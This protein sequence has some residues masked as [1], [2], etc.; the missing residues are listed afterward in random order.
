MTEAEVE[1]IIK[2]NEIRNKL[3]SIPYD[4]IKGI[5]GDCCERRLLKCSGLIRE[6]TYLPIQAF[7]TDK[8]PF[9]NSLT[10][11]SKME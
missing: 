4:P 11:Q 7:L 8:P 1:Y 3:L 5:G 6:N 9:Q 2:E 10:K